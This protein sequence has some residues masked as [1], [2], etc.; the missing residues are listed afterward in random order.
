MFQSNFS[1]STKSEMERVSKKKK[2][3]GEQNYQF[4]GN[5]VELWFGVGG[6]KSYFYLGG[7]TFYFPGGGLLLT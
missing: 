7:S 3:E 1:M 2:M 4:D 6:I 5:Q